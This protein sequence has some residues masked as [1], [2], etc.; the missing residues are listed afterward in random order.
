MDSYPTMDEYPSFD[1]NQI[2]QDLSYENIGLLYA[3]SRAFLNLASTRLEEAR[4]A[5]AQMYGVGDVNL[6]G[7]VVASTIGRMPCAR[8]RFLPPS[9]GV[10]D[11]I[12]ASGMI[13]DIKELIIEIP[14]PAQGVSPEVVFTTLKSKS[15]EE[16]H[17]AISLHR[18]LDVDPRASGVIVGTNSEGRVFLHHAEEDIEYDE[19]LS[20][21]DS[22]SPEEMAQRLA[23][24]SLYNSLLNTYVLGNQSRNDGTAA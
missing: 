14:E 24:I 17:H 3:E 6:V 9:K 22:A 15:G 23:K 16:S 21:P 2:P 5:S 10:I 18:V 4:E 13:A 19:I 20:D 11:H 8:L 12:S 7:H 1:G